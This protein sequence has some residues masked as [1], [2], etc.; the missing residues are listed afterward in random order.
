MN[1]SAASSPPE[2]DPRAAAVRRSNLR[3]GVTLGSIALVFFA[4]II[5]V[6]FL[7][8]MEAGITIVGAAVFLFL[9]VAIGRNLWGK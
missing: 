6:Q 1:V 5:A 4:G 3:V 9:V 2:P 8:G 7:G